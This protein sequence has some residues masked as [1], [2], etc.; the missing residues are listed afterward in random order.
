MLDEDVMNYFKNEV[1]YFSRLKAERVQSL[2]HY[3][4]MNSHDFEVVNL[5]GVFSDEASADRLT[6]N[7]RE[8]FLK[9]RGS[10]VKYINLSGNDLG[11][12]DVN[13]IIKE[14]QYLPELRELDLTGSRIT[15]ASKNKLSQALKSTNR[16]KPLFVET[17]NNG[18]TRKYSSSPFFFFNTMSDEEFSEHAKK[19]KAAF[20]KFDSVED[21]LINVLF[22]LFKENQIADIIEKL[23]P[24]PLAEE[25]IPSLTFFDE[26]LDDFFVGREV[27]SGKKFQL[28]LS[29]MNKRAVNVHDPESTTQSN[30][31][32]HDE[33]DPAAKRQRT[34]PE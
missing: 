30:K 14:L 4:S 7:L 28:L 2:S 3:L 32:E 34:R 24:L 25:I 20:S 16:T 29:D 12:R 22:V 11:E 13:L 17:N 31:R 5:D 10:P 1:G 19:A 6:E 18:Q 21:S 9:L 23:Q 26:E 15:E 27:A 33:Q 8:L